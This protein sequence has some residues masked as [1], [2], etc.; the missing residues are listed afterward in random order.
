MR[1]FKGFLR[2]AHRRGLRVIIELVLNPHLDQHHV[3]AGRQA[4]LGNHWREFYVWS[5]TPEKYREARIIFNDFE[6]SNWTWDPIAQA[7]YWHRFYAHQ[8]DLN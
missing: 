5:D 4:K 7:H 1:D 3:S 2:Q 8:P 6:P